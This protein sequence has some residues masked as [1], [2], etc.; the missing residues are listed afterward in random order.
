MQPCSTYAYYEEF[1]RK[2]E[3][4]LRRSLFCESCVITDHSLLEVKSNT[5]ALLKNAEGVGFSIKK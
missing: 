3:K 4:Y 2:L 1:L 5:D